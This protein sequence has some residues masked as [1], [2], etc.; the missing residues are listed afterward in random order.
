M[1]VIMKEIIQAGNAVQRD[2]TFF[3]DHVVF[4]VENTLFKV[5]RIRFE[6]DSKVFASMFLL[7]PGDAAVEGMD[8]KSPIKLE[9][10][11]QRD[12][13]NLLHVIYPNLAPK[14]SDLS[15]DELL[16]MLHLSTMWEFKEARKVVVA[17]LNEK[18]MD[19]IQRVQ[20]AKKAKVSQW[21]LSA[22]T[23][24]VSSAKPLTLREIGTLDWE[25]IARLLLVQQQRPELWRK[26]DEILRY[27]VQCDKGFP[28]LLALNDLIPVNS[29]FFDVERSVKETFKSELLS[30]QAWE[31][32]WEGR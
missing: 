12:F 3:L 28:H 13:R 29:E 30:I 7:P 24:L 32:E 14:C 11:R 2:D 23:K 6:V 27:R 18:P 25:I 5:P 22:Y 9:G 26:Q 17:K 4:L 19:A 1:P 16:A 10:I 21:L 31:A 15:Q 20:L 8:E